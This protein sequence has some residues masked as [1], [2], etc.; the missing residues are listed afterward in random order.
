MAWQ[1][2][3]K[4][5]NGDIYETIFHDISRKMKSGHR[6]SLISKTLF[7]V[8]QNITVQCIRFR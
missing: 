7:H 1:I 4:K 2:K 3:V 6:K 5:D 8:K